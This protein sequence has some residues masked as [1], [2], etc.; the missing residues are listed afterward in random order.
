MNSEKDKTT[1]KENKGK[2][3]SNLLKFGIAGSLIGLAMFRKPKMGL[4]AG[5]GFGL[6]LCHPSLERGVKDW[7]KNIKVSVK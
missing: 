1:I 7:F 2:V 3:I 6:G 5:C 4:I